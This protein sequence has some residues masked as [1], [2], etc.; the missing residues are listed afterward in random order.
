L[1]SEKFDR[2]SANRKDAVERLVELANVFSG[3]IPLTRV[4][5]NG[6]NKHLLSLSRFLYC[7]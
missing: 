2:W 4:E 6:T 3:T 1:L 5:K 7:F